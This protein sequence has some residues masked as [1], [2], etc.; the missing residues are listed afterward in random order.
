MCTFLMGYK[1]NQGCLA[2]EKS[3][4][5]CIALNSIQMIEHTFTDRITMDSFLRS[6]L[7]S[8]SW[9]VCFIYVHGMYTTD[10]QLIVLVKQ[11]GYYFYM[12]SFVCIIITICQM[13]CPVPV[14]VVIQ[15]IRSVK[16]CLIHSSYPHVTIIN[17]V[18]L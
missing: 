10:L 12:N 8:V 1:L 14:N 6:R 11:S 2:L 18:L 5:L 17:L 9:L 7:P 15:E 13:Q 3:N 4:S 16:F